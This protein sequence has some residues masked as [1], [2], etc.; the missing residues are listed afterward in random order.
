MGKR[1][2][3]GSKKGGDKR[4]NNT[5]DDSWGTARDDAKLNDAFAQYYKRIVPAE[6][7]D[8]FIETL[9]QEL[10]ITFRFNGLLQ[11]GSPATVLR[12]D[13]IKTH[14]AGSIEKPETVTAEVDNNRGE[15]IL[16]FDVTGPHQ[17][18]WYPAAFKMTIPKLVLRKNADYR[19]LHEYLKI[20]HVQG[21]ITRQEAVSMVPPLFLD[22]QPG[23]R[24]IDMC[25]APGSKSAQLVDMAMGPPH[26]PGTTEKD[27][28]I[29]VANDAERDRAYLLCFNLSRIGSP[30][31][32]ITCHDAGHYPHDPDTPLYD[33]VLADVPC[34]GDG[35]LRKAPDLWRRWTPALGVGLHATQLRIAI[36]AFNLLKPGCRMVYSTCSFNP[37]EN[38]AVVAAMLQHVHGA[39]LVDTTGQMPELKRRPGLHAWDVFNYRS[40]EYVESFDKLSEEDQKKFVATMFPPAAETAADLHLERCMRFYPHDGD[41]GGFFVAVIQKAPATEEEL[42]REK[43]RAA[44]R[45]ERLKEAEAAPA[46]T[47]ESGV[48][49][50]TGKHLI[51]DI[52]N[53]TFIE[54]AFLPVVPD[55]PYIRTIRDFF[56]IGDDFPI[57]NT[58]VRGQHSVNKPSKLYV[59]PPPAMEFI[60]KLTKDKKHFMYNLIN[61]GIDVFSHCNRAQETNP[62]RITQQAANLVGPMCTKRVIDMPREQLAGFFKYGIVGLIDRPDEDNSMENWLDKSVAELVTALS[63][64][65][66]LVRVPC[67]WGKEYYAMWRAKASVATLIKKDMLAVLCGEFGVTM[68]MPRDEEIARHEKKRAKEAEDE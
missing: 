67:R 61:C 5:R 6:E 58:V 33:R 8:T 48:P 11:D 14:C 2:G 34:S 16:K 49:T 51:V 44:R 10:P 27:T 13:F 63:T 50:E 41:T 46:P 42:A 54:E 60:N 57:A 21:N 64:G 43:T 24:V 12:E 66:F 30:L 32:C 17:M 29:V 20:Q 65:C 62:W 35:T 26:L 68:V 47:D 31:A 4:S 28:G 56:G 22:V 52:N 23:H 9:L 18:K 53:R 1:K 3:R 37:I 38:E 15:G 59:V 55:A 45:E 19:A 40:K 7:W 36:R 25:A 39:T